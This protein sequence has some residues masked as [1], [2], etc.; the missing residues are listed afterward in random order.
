MTEA[1]W[2]ATISLQFPTE[3]NWGMSVWTL[4]IGQI[5]AEDIFFF[6]LIVLA[7]SVANPSRTF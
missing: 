4:E 6:P 5:S 3:N 1:K 2:K 7:L